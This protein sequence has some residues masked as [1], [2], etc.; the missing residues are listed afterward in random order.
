ML[1]MKN[2]EFN[3]ALVFDEYKR[4]Q[5]PELKNKIIEHYLYIADI[6]SRRFLN[7][8][9]EYEDIY[10]VACLGLLLAVNRF[11]PGRKI[12]FASYATP[13]V[14][15]EIRKYFRDK[16]Y[17]IKIP[18]TLYEVFY[19][20]ERIRRSIHPEKCSN[21]DISKI[22]NIT[23]ETLQKAYDVGGAAFIQ[24][25]EQEAY[26][27]GNMMYIDTV[28]YDDNNFLMIENKDFISYCMNSLDKKEAEFIKLRFY[29]NCTQKQI[30]EKWNMSQMQIS[31]YEKKILAKLKDLYFK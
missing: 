8:G 12:K 24:S 7:R 10:Q 27:D 15:G 5:N 11:D 28:G 17:F 25:L 29:E 21:D 19:R 23:P 4:T 14:L 1:V 13:T 30:S 16:G 18:R 20:A 6:L 26:A 9:I 31:R 22:M 3:E 2:E